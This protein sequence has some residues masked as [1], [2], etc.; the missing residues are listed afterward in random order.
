MGE[1][2]TLKAEDGFEIDAYLALPSGTPKGAVVVIQE[3]FGVNAHIREDA[4]TFA[5]AG[6]AAI[7]P[8]MFDRMQKNV[9]LAYDAD[10]VEAGR[11][12]A[13]KTDWDNVVKDLRAASG[14]VKQY[15]KVGL[16]GY[17]WGGT[18]AWVSAVRDCGVDC[19]SG[20]YGGKVID[21]VGEVAESAGDAALRRQR[22]RHPDRDSREDQSRRT[23]RCR[24]TGTPRPSTASTATSGPSYHAESD[25][26]STERTMAFFKEHH[27]LIEH[28]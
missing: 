2:I 18:V 8:G 4:D 28:G 16:V 15:G 23:P 7:A 19:A 17:C 22:P 24:F 12:F 1:D 6:Y 5:K 20:Y 26:L 9:D 10:G 14:A 27:R 13:M 11:G 21:F 25:K 3:I